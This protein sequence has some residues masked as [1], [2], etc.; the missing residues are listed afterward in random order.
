MARQNVSLTGDKRFARALKKL[1]RPELDNI[2][3]KGLRRAGRLSKLRTQ[4]TYLSG[5]PLRRITGELFGSIKLAARDPNTEIIIGTDLRQAGPLHFGWPKH[6]LRPRPFL[7]PAVLDEFPR[8]VDIWI[9]EIAK[10][11]G[12]VK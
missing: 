12:S 8:F 1:R 11:L 5:S 2:N 4:S 10:S 7:F 6:N 9:D 3:R